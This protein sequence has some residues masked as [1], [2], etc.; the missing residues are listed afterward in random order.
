MSKFQFVMPPQIGGPFIPS[1]VLQ[2]A[3]ECAFLWTQRANAVGEPNFR[4]RDL[5]RLDNRVEAHADGLRVAADAGWNICTET[6]AFE[7]PGEIFTAALLAFESKQRERID[8]VLGAGE[9]GSEQSSGIVS[10]IGWLSPTD[11]LPFVTLLLE[12]ADRK[13]HRIGVAAA[14]TH[15]FLPRALGRELNSPDAAARARAYRLVGE[16]GADDQTHTL[17]VNDPDE[18]C[19]FWSSWSAARNGDR[20]GWAPLVDMALS[21][22]SCS[23]YAARMAV[24]VLERSFAV[25]F[26]AR[27]AD[28]R[29]RTTTAG[30]LG[31]PSAIPELLER[32]KDPPLARVA[33]EA[34]SMIT[35]ADL[36][37]ADFEGG[38]PEG[39]ESGPNDD[40]DDDEVEMDPDE[41][42]PWPNVEAVERWWME[43]R[44]EYQDGIRYLCGKP[45]TIES[46]NEVLRTGYQRQRAAAAIE[47]AIRQPGQP[48]FEVRAPGFRQQQLLGLCRTPG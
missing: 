27:L 30:A 25:D 14:A 8:R 2:H 18:T 17:D 16:L 11:G 44:S 34:F 7:W 42:L 10:A 9:I 40:P 13:L 4:L 35:G 22:G 38:P 48:L 19:R 46:L 39:F 45:M 21:N 15:R 37:F 32:M 43:H 23:E 3:E 29:V 24:R 28:L 5:A 36:A 41:N 31:I 1:V 26:Q 6:L 20:R 12:S 33:G 47:L